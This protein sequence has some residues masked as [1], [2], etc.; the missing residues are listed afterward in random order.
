[1][2]AST[3]HFLAAIGSIA[4]PLL[5]GLLGFLFRGIGRWTVGLLSATRANT[6][7][8][9]NLTAQLGSTSGDVTKLTAD[10]GELSTQTA[11]NTEHIARNTSRI[12]KLE[13]GFPS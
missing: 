11:L 1:M 3:L 12:R 6:E 7:A 9:S 2:S 10:V 13:K 4:T 8:I 5:V